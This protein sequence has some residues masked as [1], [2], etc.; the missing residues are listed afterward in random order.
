MSI[1]AP[2]KGRFVVSCTEED[3]SALNFRLL[4]ITSSYGAEE[5][6]LQPESCCGS[7]PLG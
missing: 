5:I 4:K 6:I 2:E 7:V 3:V 1:V